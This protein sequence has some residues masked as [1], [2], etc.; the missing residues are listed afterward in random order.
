[1]RSITATTEKSR[2]SMGRFVK[3]TDKLAT[4]STGLNQASQSIGQLAQ[5][6]DEATRP[7]RDFEDAMADLEGITGVSGKALE[8]LG[9]AARRTTL[10]MGGEASKSVETYKLLLSQLGPDLAGTPEVLDQM[11]RNVGMLSKTMGGDTTAAAE[12]LTTAMNQYKV[13]LDEPNQALAE[14]TRMMNAM[15]AG[16][17][18][19]S[20]ELP[21][22]KAGLAN[23]GGVAK[24]ANLKFEETIAALELL[25][26][27]GKKGAEGGV[28]LRNVLATLSQGRFLPKDVQA[29]LRSAGV[30]IQA[31]S[32]KSRSFTDRLRELRP[33]QQDQALLTKLF[34]KENQLAASALLQS[35]D[36]QDKMRSAITGTNTAQDQARI[37]MKTTNER[38]SRMTAWWN[39]LKISIFNSTKAYIP[40]LQ[41]SFTTISTLSRVGSAVAGVRLLM[42]SLG[43]TV[44]WMGKSFMWAAR[45]A[46][47]LAR[48]ILVAGLNALKS[49]GRFIV[50]A[51]TGLASLIASLFGAT[52]A[53]WS[54]NAAMLANPI[55]IVVAAILTW[56]AMLAGIIAAIWAVVTYW[57]DIK[58]FFADF[59]EW[60]WEHHPFKWLLDVLENQFPGFKQGVIDFFNNLWETIQSWANHV[61]QNHPFRWL[62]WLVEQVFPGFIDQVTAFFDRI[63]N[64]AVE[65]F[66]KMWQAA[67]N[68]WRD[69]KTLFGFLG[70]KVEV[71]ADEG[72]TGAI[73]N[74]T[75][76]PDT[77]G[78]FDE[79]GFTDQALNLGT[80]GGAGTNTGTGATTRG[81]NITMHLNITNNFNLDEDLDRRIDEVSEKVTSTLV[82][83]AR[84]A[85]VTVK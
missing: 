78:F 45:Q 59:F 23:V 31:L 71:V 40:F 51:A 33:I 14:M 75:G 80:G 28:A 43:T 73:E 26:K 42:A 17:K 54:L 4:L 85:A 15:A 52:T 74:L 84:D 55:G 49:A 1:M 30:D 2:D 32:D 46:W 37:K 19:G 63:Y 61:W 72:L 5:D 50:S 53:Q 9:S 6:I 83:A 35:V 34:G 41:G 39:N 67:K 38:L 69:I 25:D 58:Q 82:D 56:I 68:L 18:E 76:K 65:H 60:I 10:A 27:A 11:A 57:E 64:I 44:R 22:L 3:Q 36:A 66:E 12:V 20:A 24:D 79:K 7:G 47:S 81:R 48:G 29:E 62:I 70:D 21:A 77:P 13:S 16:A 8:E